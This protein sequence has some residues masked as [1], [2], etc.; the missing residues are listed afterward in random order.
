MIFLSYDSL[1]HVSLSERAYRPTNTAPNVGGIRGSSGNLLQGSLSRVT[2]TDSSSTASVSRPSPY[3]SSRAS[4][5]STISVRRR[6]NEEELESEETEDDRQPKVK[7][8]TVSRRGTGEGFANRG[9][10][11]KRSGYGS[12]RF[13]G[14]RDS[15]RSRSGGGRGPGRK[16]NNRT[17]EKRLLDEILGNNI[18][19]R[20]IRPSSVNR[21]GQ[22][23]A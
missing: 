9:N 14:Y 18:Y 7:W 6:G 12:R 13:T 17:R 20:K 21:T 2:R 11:S 23:K 4:E 5:K 10:R 19:D 22:F 8:D 16:E 15:M 3:H 1:R